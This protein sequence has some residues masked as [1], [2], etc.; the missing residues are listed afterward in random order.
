MTQQ[1]EDV[2]SL[3]DSGSEYFDA[4]EAGSS[5]D[6]M[7][8]P[9][10]TD[11]SGPAACDALA[12]QAHIDSFLYSS[13]SGSYGPENQSSP[14]GGDLFGYVAGLLS[15][16]GCLE[17]HSVK[18]VEVAAMR[19]VCRVRG[20]EIPVE[21]ISFLESDHRLFLLYLKNH[22]ICRTVN[23]FQCVLLHLKF[24]SKS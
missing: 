7:E 15:T 19:E 1:E 17:G 11:D 20:W 16:I 13:F 21:L 12:G 10:G 18:P 5:A 9:L 2:L 6:E 3:E 23:I 14:H 22:F 8:D 4:A 24:R